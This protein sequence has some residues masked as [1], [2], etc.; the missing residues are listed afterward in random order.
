MADQFFSIIQSQIANQDKG[1]RVKM[2]NEVTSQTQAETNDNDAHM[3]TD[4]KDA[5]KL[6]GGNGP[7]QTPL[8]TKERFNIV[9]LS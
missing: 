3:N 9:I 2:E 7:P 6:K 4:S 5:S 1:D 8:D